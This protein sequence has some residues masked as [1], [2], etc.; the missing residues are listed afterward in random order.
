MPITFDCPSCRKSM[1]VRDRMAGQTANCPFCKAPMT[2][3]AISPSAFVPDDAAK[4]DIKFPCPGCGSR[5]VAAPHEAGSRLPCPGCMRRVVVPAASIDV[6]SERDG[7][8]P[9]G[10][11]AP[12]SRVV[13]VGVD[14]PFGDLFML[15][16]KVWFALGL[17]SAPFVLIY[18]VLVMNSSAGR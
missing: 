14:M 6:P 2:V 8:P 10:L 9:V 1:T 13:F 7:S 15:V 11:L 3:P 12:P 17:I 18:V 16:L 4:A 5:L